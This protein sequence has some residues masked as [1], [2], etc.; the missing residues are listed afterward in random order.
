MIEDDSQEKIDE[1]YTV[2]TG[3][4]WDAYANQIKDTMERG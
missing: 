2:A 4:T 1:M 3:Y